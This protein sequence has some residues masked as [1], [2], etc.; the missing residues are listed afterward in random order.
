MTIH[1][2]I[3]CIAGL[4]AGMTEAIL[5]VT[6]TETIKYVPSSPKPDFQEDRLLIRAVLCYDV[7]HAAG[8]FLRGDASELADSLIVCHKSGHNSG[9]LL[10]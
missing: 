10:A 9:Y 2:S 4:G 6:P 8:C 1:L 7:S 5:V 3:C